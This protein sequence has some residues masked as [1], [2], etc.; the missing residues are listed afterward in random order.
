VIALFASLLGVLI[1]L[2]VASSSVRRGNA[3]VRALIASDQAI[4]QSL[5]PGSLAAIQLDARI[6]ATVTMY[7]SKLVLPSAR[8]GAAV[9]GVI[10]VGLLA[11]ALALTLKNHS[12]QGD[13]FVYPFVSGFFAANVGLCLRTLLHR[14][15]VWAAP[16]PEAARVD[17]GVIA[18]DDDNS[19]AAEKAAGQPI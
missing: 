13:Q 14:N 4:L 3:K 6:Q 9:M 16:D 5:P 15:L 7:A 19:S 12:S 18:E 10:S 17:Q 11:G 8:R 1:A 2:M